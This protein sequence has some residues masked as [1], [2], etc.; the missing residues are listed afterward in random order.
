MSMMDQTGMA[1]PQGD[2]FASI[3]RDLLDQ[4]RELATLADTDQEALEVEKLTTA[5]AK[6]LADQE[7]QHQ[8]MLG[9][10]ASPGML[11]KALGGR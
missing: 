2:R 7:K 10:K 5:L 9:G 3:V 4:A 6:M 8:D 11:A 1:P